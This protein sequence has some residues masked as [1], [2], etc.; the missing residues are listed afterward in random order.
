MV[1]V[2][3]YVV[4][5]EF[6]DILPSSRIGT[7]GVGVGLGVV[8]TSL[9]MLVAVVLIKVLISGYLSFHTKVCSF[10]CMEEILSMAPSNIPQCFT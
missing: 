7:V 5:T 4:G 8:M 3:S 2:S 1:K 10:P 9:V 6:T